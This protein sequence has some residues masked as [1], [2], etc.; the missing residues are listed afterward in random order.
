MNFASDNS[1]GASEPIL[2]ALTAA[3]QGA[4]PAYGSDPCT[5]RAGQLLKDVFEHDLVYFLVST[6][7]AANALAL[8][9]SSPPYGAIFCH[10]RAHIATDECGAP[11][12]FTGG[13]KLVGI[14]GHGGKIIPADLKCCLADFPRGVV[15]HVQ[16]AVLSLSQV[17]EC[18][19]VYRCEE[20]AE[21]A[22]LA[23]AA[24]L[25][26][27]MDGAR[28]ANAL[29]SL[30]CTPAEMSW[31][32]GVDILSFGATKNGALACEA[33]IVFDPAKAWSLPYWRKRSGHT[34][35]KGRYLGAQMA[36]YLDNGHWLALAKQ[37][38]GLARELAAGM[39]HIPG[40]RMPWPCEANEVFA[41]LPGPVDRALRER[42]AVYYPWPFPQEG[43]GV[44]A[45]GKDEA[46][47]RLVTSFATLEAEVRDFLSIASETA[48][49]GSQL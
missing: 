33:V 49:L 42:G 16:P 19:T 21:L 7:T 27:H 6:G 20:I 3:N 39:A 5:A 29:V 34:L 10:E 23:H 36:A 25:I 32:A 15:H 46:Y 40:I 45:P 17:T 4:L 41:I 2:A 22:R 14:P 26:V 24:D 37:A 31:K 28:F 43:A 12:M 48:A 1:C 13:A 18:G 8:A 47:V 44:T 30:G 38:N 11:E 35:S 9:A